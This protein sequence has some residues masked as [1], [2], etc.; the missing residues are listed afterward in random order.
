MSATDYTIVLK[1]KGHYDE[2][3]A[4][5]AIS[6]GMAATLAADG[7]WDQT[8]AAQ[9]AALKGGLTLALES[10]LNGGTVSDAYADGD[11][12]FLYHPLPGD[13]VNVLVKSGEDIDIGDLLVVEG[14]T[15]GLFVE[16]AGTETKFQLKAI[17]G[18][19]ALAAN[20]LVACRVLAP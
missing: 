18:P 16:A 1:G 17:E 2:G 12:I 7:L 3:E 5:G 9:A 11:R 13:V 10:A 20:T 15:S 8:V 19:G 4:D 6:P 14:G